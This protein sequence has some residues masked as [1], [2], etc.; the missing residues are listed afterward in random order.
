MY[1]ILL[2]HMMSIYFKLF[3]SLKQIILYFL[4]R[5][6]HINKLFL[7]SMIASVYL[8]FWL[9]MYLFFN[10]SIHVPNLVIISCLVTILRYHC[11]NLRYIMSYMQILKKILP[12]S[13]VYV[14]N[15]YGDKEKW[16]KLCKVMRK[17][18][19]SR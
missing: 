17:R 7:I 15:G 1:N 13:L 12:P 5:F 19:K 10:M 18:K 11:Y 8:I 4:L 2:N 9:Y 14:W 16:I 6:E 3:W